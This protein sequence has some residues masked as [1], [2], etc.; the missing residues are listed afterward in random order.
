[1]TPQRKLQCQKCGRVRYESR[2]EVVRVRGVEVVLC[3]ARTTCKV[4]KR[5]S[6]RVQR[7]S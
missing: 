6:R 2:M 5:E 7:K 3:A 4:L 1:M